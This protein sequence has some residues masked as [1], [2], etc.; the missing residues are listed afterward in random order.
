[1]SIKMIQFILFP[2]PFDHHRLCS[3][4]SSVAGKDFIEFINPVSLEVLTGCKAE[5]SLEGAA[6]PDAFQFLRLGYFAVD[7]NDSKPGS[8]VF[9]R[10]V[11]LKDGFKK[12]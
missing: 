1:M 11:A 12:V 4:P 5:K 7:S 3:L 9:N 2:S 10:A 8:L 6:A